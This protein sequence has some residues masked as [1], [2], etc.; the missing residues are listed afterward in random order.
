MTDPLR[1]DQDS[2]QDSE[3]TMTAPPRLRPDGGASSDACDAD[4]GTSGEDAAATHGVAPL[5]LADD[6]LRREMTH[7]HTTRHDTVLGGT[8]DALQ[9]HTTR[10]LALEAEFLRRLPDEAAP[11]PRRTRAGSR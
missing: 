5:D 7:L 9:V 8:E 6:D 2:D 11:D 1:H 10:M 3:A 4:V